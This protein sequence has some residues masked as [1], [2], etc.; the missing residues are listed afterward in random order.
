ML[1]LIIALV[2]VSSCYSQTAEEYFNKG[3]EKAKHKKYEG[4]IANFTKAIEINP[5]DAMSYCKRGLAKYFSLSLSSKAKSK[6]FLRDDNWY[7]PFNINS[8][9]DLYEYRWAIDDFTKAIEIDSMCAEV[10]YNVGMIK[11]DL[12]DHEGA[13]ADYSKAIEISPNYAN[14][15]YKRAWARC[16]FGD[17]YGGCSDFRKARDL[18]CEYEE[19]DSAKEDCK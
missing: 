16:G 8:N 15:Y 9:V 4:A 13:I 11:A 14:A 6:S 5:K 7:T 17:I 19:P 3:L 18:G 10:Y 12:H 1:H 2:I